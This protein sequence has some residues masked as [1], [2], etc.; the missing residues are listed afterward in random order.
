MNEFVLIFLL[1]L[2]VIVFGLIVVVLI[3]DEALQSHTLKDFEQRSERLSELR[4]DLN[5]KEN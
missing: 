3:P 4:R 2:G 5:E 1:A